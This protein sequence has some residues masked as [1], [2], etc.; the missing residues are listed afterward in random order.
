MHS[1]TNGWVL[2]RGQKHPSSVL[3]RTTVEWKVLIVDRY[4]V[5]TT[6]PFWHS[7]NESVQNAVKTLES[8]LEVR[9]GRSESTLDFLVHSPPERTQLNLCTCKFLVTQM[10]KYVLVLVWSC[11]NYS[12]IWI[13]PSGQTT[14]KT[15][16][17][18]LVRTCAQLVSFSED[19]SSCTH[20]C[21]QRLLCAEISP[22]TLSS[23]KRLFFEQFL[24]IPLPFEVCCPWPACASCTADFFAKHH[25]RTVNL[26]CHALWRILK[27][28]LN[29]CPRSGS[30][31]VREQSHWQAGFIFDKFGSHNEN[32]C[33]NGPKWKQT[34]PMVEG[35]VDL[36]LCLPPP[37]WCCSHASYLRGCFHSWLE[38]HRTAVCLKSF[39]SLEDTMG[40]MSTCQCWPKQKQQQMIPCQK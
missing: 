21:N 34:I 35:C 31:I 19:S 9:S 11:T 8:W 25:E 30:G 13:Q 17:Q 2:T 22:E 12:C 3:A 33:A 23:P 7:D 26:L 36:S 27:W 1:D 10:R 16:K 24:T 29:C 37:F 28:G 14:N 6:L 5:L 20:I 39:L 38:M 15:W 40:D 4:I 32:R 18:V